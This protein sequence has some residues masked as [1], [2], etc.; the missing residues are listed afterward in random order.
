M[1]PAGMVHSMPKKR[2]FFPTEGHRTTTRQTGDGSHATLFSYLPR[3]LGAC[4]L[5]HMGSFCRKTEY[6]RYTGGN[7][8][9][10]S[11]TPTPSRA[12][13]AGILPDSSGRG[14]ARPSGEI[15]PGLLVGIRSGGSERRGVAEM[16]TPTGSER[17]R[18][19]Q[20]QTVLNSGQNC[21]WVNTSSFGYT[22]FQ[23]ANRDPLPT[24]PDS[25]P[26]R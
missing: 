5:S 19:K 12:T 11:T 25:S 24:L 20:P 6:R 9:R 15:L 21:Y 7:L 16:E 2:Q 10:I 13:A 26:S 18:G 17:G 14:C 8:H 22:R 1:D 3:D 4:F 23:P